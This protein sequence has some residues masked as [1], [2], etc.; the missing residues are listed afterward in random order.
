[1]MTQFPDA[2]IHYLALTYLII[3]SLDLEWKKSSPTLKQQLSCIYIYLYQLL[4]NTSKYST[5]WC[6]NEDL[7]CVFTCMRKMAKSICVVNG[8]IN[9]WKQP[10]IIAKHRDPFWQGTNCHSRHAVLLKQKQE[11]FL[12]Q[13]FDK[14]Y[15][16]SGLIFIVIFYSYGGETGIMQDSSVNT[17]AADAL[18]PCI[19][20]ASATIVLNYVW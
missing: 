1:M 6:G 13:F 16:Y 11:K 14:D 2:N 15:F 10:Q 9:S 19:A 5:Q 12:W 7:R 17:I 18:A 3:R 4:Q 20:K 8:H